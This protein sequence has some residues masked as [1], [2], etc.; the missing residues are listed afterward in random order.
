MQNDDLLTFAEENEPESAI[1]HAHP[2]EVWRILVVGDDVDVHKA[3]ELA[4]RDHPILQRSLAFLHAYTAEQA[5]QILAQEKDIAVILL[6]VVMETEDAGLRTISTI[7][8]ELE[9]KNVRI[10]LRTGQPGHAPE[11]DTIVRY[12][13]ND[14][15]TKNELTRNKLFTTLTT[16]IRSYEQLR[17]LESNRKGLEKIVAAS[18]H[19]M[20]KSG[21]RQFADGV[22]TQI[23]GLLGIAPEGVVCVRED[24]STLGGKLRIIAAAGHY[25]HLVQ[26]YLDEINEPHIIAA[27]T[28]CFK[29]QETEV[30]DD[31]IVL[32]FHHNNSPFFAAYIDSTRQLNEVDIRLLDVF[33]TNISLCAENV[34][35]VSR[36]HD[37]AYFDA[38]VKL[39]NRL[40]FIEEIDNKLQNDGASDTVIALIDID[41]FAAINDMLG[42]QYGDHLLQ[43]V[44][45][46][47]RASLP[48][49][50][51][52]ARVSGDIFGVLGHINDL[53]P[54]Q[55]HP[56]FRD[57][58]FVENTEHS[59]TISIG[60]VVLDNIE[61]NGSDYLKDAHIALKR[62]KIGGISQSAYYSTAI[63]TETR[64]RAVLLQNLRGAFDCRRLYLVYQPQINL[65]SR[66]TLGFEALLRWQADDDVHI[67]PDRF[68]PVAEY[69]G[70]IVPLGAWVLRTALHTLQEMNA[71]SPTPLRMAVNV[72]VVQLRQESFLAMLDSALRDTGVDPS[73]LELEL[74][75]SFAIL[76]LEHIRHLIREIKKRGV[77]IAIDDFGTG[78]S[79]LS[80]IDQL[81]VDRIKIDRA[82][83]TPLDSPSDG[84]RIVELVIPMGHRLGMTVI[85]EGVENEKHL[86]ALINLGC[87]E[88]QGFYFARPMPI[89]EAIAWVT[90]PSTNV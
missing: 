68:I 32:C 22:I 25:Q 77:L 46:H 63:G 10:I 8:N 31:N 89:K 27:L 44:A 49:D 41:Q 70:L 72:S 40:A 19:L 57:P 39:P 11:I 5:L 28:H 38:L 82:F 78:Y 4:L 62:A 17:T 58:L 3:T 7:R 64:E 15:K 80:Y 37:Q 79:S 69:S 76:G 51:M 66:K 65:S 60:L 14:Y 45:Q 26:H 90:P 53:R 61:N 23:S 30:N 56:I 52:V 20:G 34:Q 73:L 43:S 55:L 12:D 13:I 84:A 35:L 83:I 75:E 67:A 16:A 88:A 47:L 86:N 1:T 50:C 21:L 2:P 87:D 71:V 24:Q 59:I 48:N 74:T 54:N 18:N 9:L 85:A 33:C 6:D 81:P 36:L 29:N 42:H